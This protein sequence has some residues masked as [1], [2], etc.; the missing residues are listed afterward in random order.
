MGRGAESAVAPNRPGAE[1]A[2]ARRPRM[3]SRRPDDHVVLDAIR[4]E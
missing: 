4:P 2:A 3:P 1:S